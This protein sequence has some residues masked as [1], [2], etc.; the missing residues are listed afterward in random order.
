VTKGKPAK[1]ALVEFIRWVLTEGQKF[2]PETGYINLSPEK[3]REG[4]SRI[5]A[6]T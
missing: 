6:G 4:L 1:P 5:G 2:V 3:L